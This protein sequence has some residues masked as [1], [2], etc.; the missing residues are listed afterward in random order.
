MEDERRM[1]STETLPGI[2]DPG[3][4]QPGA[5]AHEKPLFREI[6]ETFLL[7]TII[8]LVVNGTTGRFRVEGESMEPNMHDGQYVIVN[9]LAYATIG[10]LELGEPERGDVVVFRFPRDPSRDFIKRVIGL[11]GERIE[12]AN[13]RVRVCPSSGAAC[14]ALAE[15]YIRQVPNYSGVW[16]LGPDE[17]FVLG[18]NRNNSSDSHNWGPLTVEQIIGRAWVSYWPPPYWGEIPHYTYN[19]AEAN[20]P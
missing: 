16:T 18:D 14:E 20:T 1:E 15:P 11:P 12:V 10:S 3:A 6:V 4:L 8:F 19:G 7:A 2:G 13:G 5:E 17:F 9:R